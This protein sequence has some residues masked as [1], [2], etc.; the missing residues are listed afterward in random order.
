MTNEIKVGSLNLLS[1]RSVGTYQG[2]ELTSSS[3]PQSSRKN[4]TDGANFHFI[5]PITATHATLSLENNPYRAKFDI[6]RVITM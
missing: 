1:S 5:N 2:K 3:R 6:L 4:S